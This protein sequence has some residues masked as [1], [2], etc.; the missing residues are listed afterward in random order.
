MMFPYPDRFY[1]GIGSRETPQVILNDMTDI[2]RQLYATHTCRSGGAGGADSAC[3]TGAGDHKQI[4]LPYD[5]FNGRHVDDVYFFKLT[6]EIEKQARKMAEYYHPAWSRCSFAA[7][8]FHTRNV[9]QVL[10]PDLKTPVEFVLCYTER[11]LM[12]GGTA[13]ALRIAKDHDIPIF[14][15]GK[16][17]KNDV[18]YLLQAY[19]K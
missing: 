17:T 14:N 2:C 6:G 12:K 8:R 5:G 7:R 16:Y 9:P 1:A 18:L 11:G 13:Q 15:L 19:V 10:G 3:E 4:F